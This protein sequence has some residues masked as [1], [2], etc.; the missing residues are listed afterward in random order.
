MHDYYL[1]KYE[2]NHKKGTIALSLEDPH[3]APVHQ[4]TAMFEG[5][6]AYKFVHDTF[7]LGTILFSISE[8]D[9]NEIYGKYGSEF[10]LD[11]PYGWPGEWAKSAEEACNFF[12]EEGVKGYWI[13]PSLGLSGW[14]LAKA[15]EVKSGNDAG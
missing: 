14:V 4:V 2:V 10:L 15:Y 3:A 8:I 9:P 5:C 13:V 7:H 12:E 11:L 1:S 6:V